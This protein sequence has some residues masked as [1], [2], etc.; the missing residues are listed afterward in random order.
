MGMCLPRVQPNWLICSNCGLHKD[1]DSNVNQQHS[2]QM[3]KYILCLTTWLAIY[4]QN[5]CWAQQD[6]IM[7]WHA[8]HKAVSS[9]RCM[10]VRGP[11][12]M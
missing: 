7:P 6:S 11:Y 8:S 3:S 10:L 1:K 2:L 5:Q 9:N 4:R 12:K